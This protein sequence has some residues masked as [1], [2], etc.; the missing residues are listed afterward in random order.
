MKCSSTTGSFST[1]VFDRAPFMG[2]CGMAF[3]RRRNMPVKGASVFA[4]DLQ[5]S[6]AFFSDDSGHDNNVRHPPP[7]VRHTSAGDLRA[8]CRPSCGGSPPT[9]SSWPGV[10][11]FIRLPYSL[12]FRRRLHHGPPLNGAC[13]SPGLIVPNIATGGC[14]RFGN[15]MLLYHWLL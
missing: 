4:V 10:P 12:S 1:M 3:L 9:H 6:Q 2:C 11:P 5:P 8:F 15:E 13:W 14:S 7:L